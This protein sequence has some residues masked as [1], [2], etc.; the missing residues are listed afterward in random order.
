MCIQYSQFQ[1][2]GE[3]VTANVPKVSL[4]KAEHRT[5]CN[6]LTFSLLELTVHHPVTG[7]PFLRGLWSRE[8][9]MFNGSPPWRAIDKRT[10]LVLEQGMPREDHRRFWEHLGPN[11]S[12]G[13]V[14]KVDWLILIENGGETTVASWP[15]FGAR[16]QVRFCDSCHSLILEFKSLVLHLTI[17]DS[18][19]SNNKH[20]NGTKRIK[21]LNLLE[22]LD[23][24]KRSYFGAWYSRKWTKIL[25]R[26]LWR[27]PVSWVG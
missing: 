3:K 25:R 8:A 26:L 24:Y 16:F 7:E 17:H 9:I 13:Q 12:L 15:P 6:N 18:I 14:T 19:H 4:D 10:Q 27:E 23:S 11:F 1:S 2:T 21:F 5:I 22:S 20:D